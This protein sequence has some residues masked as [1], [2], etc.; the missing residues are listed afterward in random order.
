MQTRAHDQYGLT[1]DCYRCMLGST[2]AAVHT[3]P[4]EL[5]FFIGMFTSFLK[6]KYSANCFGGEIKFNSIKLKFLLRKVK[7]KELPFYSDV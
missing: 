7:T 6:K 3:A 5:F 4:A 1:I 2:R